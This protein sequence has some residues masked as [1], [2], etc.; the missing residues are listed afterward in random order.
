MNYPKPILNIDEQIEHLENKGVKFS[1]MDKNQE[2]LANN[3]NY[4]KLTAYRK[5]FKKHPDGLFVDKYVDLDF[6]MLKDLSIIDMRL[7][8]ALLHMALDIEHFAKVK[9]M[10]TLEKNNDDG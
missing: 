4:F 9:I 6:A 1:I 2:F 10:S 8:Y 7:R 5:V 3:N